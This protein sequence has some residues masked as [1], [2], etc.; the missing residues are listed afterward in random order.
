M[1]EQQQASGAKDLWVE[2]GLRCGGPRWRMGVDPQRH[3]GDRGSRRSPVSGLPG[4][5]RAKAKV[6]QGAEMIGLGGVCARPGGRALGI[7]R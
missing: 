1:G 2:G 7:P 6:N 4:N 3:T 5:R